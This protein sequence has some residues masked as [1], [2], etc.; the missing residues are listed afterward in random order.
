MS[1]CTSKNWTPLST[2]R[3][4][5][6]QETPTLHNSILNDK[7]V[8][9]TGISQAS[10]SG[11]RNYRRRKQVELG[12]TNGENGEEKDV[13]AIYGHY[14]FLQVSTG[15]YVCIPDYIN[16]IN[17]CRNQ[18]PSQCTSAQSFAGVVKAYLIWLAI[19]FGILWFFT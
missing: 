19:G 2:W 18:Y 12:I 11:V 8:G 1:I 10:T 17:I 16:H 13:V 14:R 5:H 9:D 3:S 6:G 7:D 4:P 15:F